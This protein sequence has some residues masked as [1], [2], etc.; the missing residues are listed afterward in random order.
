VRL[1]IRDITQKDAGNFYRFHIHDCGN[2]KFCL[3]MSSKLWTDKFGETIRI[4]TT[5][6]RLIELAN[7]ILNYLGQEA[8]LKEWHPSMNEFEWRIEQEHGKGHAI[9]I[10]FIDWLRK[11]VSMH[12]EEAIEQA[13]RI[14][15][16]M[17]SNEAWLYEAARKKKK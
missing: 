5:G 15:E 13:V 1:V 4:D 11:I 7:E 16:W 12:D 9:E 6:K 17:K 8:K 14:Y 3:I 10:W 2:G